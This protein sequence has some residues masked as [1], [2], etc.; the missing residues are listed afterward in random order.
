MATITNSLNNDANFFTSTTGFTATTG[1]IKATAGDLVLTDGYVILGASKGNSGDVL[2]S[3]G[4][5]S[6][7]VWAP[8]SGG[9]GFTWAAAPSNAS[10]VNGQGAINTKVTLL[11]MTL[12]ATA[13]VGTQV[14]VQGSSTGAGGWV[15]A[16]NA[17][18]SIWCQG[19]QSTVGTGGSLASTLPSDGVILLCTGANTWNTIWVGGNITVV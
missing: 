12:P 4:S 6:V 9:A 15:I 1:D 11:T 13:A 8:A 17:L 19:T 3:Q 2:T 7:P 10:L 18:Q 16:Q 14:A 5:S